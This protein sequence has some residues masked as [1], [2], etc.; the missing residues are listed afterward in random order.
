MRFEVAWLNSLDYV[1]W[2]AGTAEKSA[3]SRST[4]PPP[5]HPGCYIKHF[6]ISDAIL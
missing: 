1:Y 6:I 4:G 5:S 2:D 3:W